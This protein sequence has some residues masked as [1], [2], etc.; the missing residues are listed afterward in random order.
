MPHLMLILATSVTLLAQTPAPVPERGK[1]TREGAEYVAAAAT[2]PTARVMAEI[3]DHQQAVSNL[4]YLCDEI[5]PRLTGSERLVQAHEWMETRMKAYGL[6]NVHRE[7]YDFG[8]SWTRGVETARII[9]HNGIALQVAQVAWSPSTHGP[10]KGE[11]ILLGGKTLDE[12]LG[13][14][15]HLKGKIVVMGSFPK[16]EGDRKDRR[17]KMMKLFSAIRTEGIAAFLLGSEKKGGFLTMTGSPKSGRFL[18]NVPAAFLN[19]EHMNTLKRLLEKH[20]SLELELNLGGAASE[21]PVQAYNSIGEIRGVEKPEEVVILGAHLDSWDLGTGAT[22]NG[23]GS[24][25]CLEALRA[26]QASGAKPR[27]TIRVVLFSGEEQGIFGSK[28]YVK[29]HAEELKNIQAVLIDDLGTGK[30]RGFAME[31]R[32]DLRPFMAEAI[33]P[34]NEMGVRELPLESSED[35]DHAPFVEAGVPAFFCIQDDEDY[36]TTTHHSQADTFE[37]VKPQALVEGAT[38]VA[39]TALGLADMAPRLPH[40]ALE[41]ESKKAPVAH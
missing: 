15:G 24:V 36:F 29:A 27:R 23:T 28:A 1:P 39:V 12:M 37:H 14:I 16:A 3:R 5:G 22:D 31:G 38:A 9:G 11:A 34:L 35:S 33:A 25:A 40:R 41:K 8:P 2:S 6:T 7:A 10:L 13:L 26:I 21:K 20:G 30:V 19:S 32:E 17:E 4:E 18:P